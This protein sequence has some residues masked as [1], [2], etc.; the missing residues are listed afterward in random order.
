M[1]YLAPPIPIRNARRSEFVSKMTEQSQLTC[2]FVGFPIPT[3]KWLIA[4]KNGSTDNAMK[5]TT[6]TVQIQPGFVKGIITISDTNEMDL[7]LYKCLVGFVIFT[8]EK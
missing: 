1:V 7:G 8:V 6:S 3:V 4:Y 2:Y 5:Y